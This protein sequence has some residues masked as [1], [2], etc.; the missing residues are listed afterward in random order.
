MFLGEL[1]SLDVK[2]ASGVGLSSYTGFPSAY[3]PDWS[4]A[5]RK[6]VRL[7]R[8]EGRSM[9]EESGWSEP[10]VRGWAE[11]GKLVSEGHTLPGPLPTADSSL[12]SRGAESTR[13]PMLDN[14]HRKLT[15]ELKED[16]LKVPA[17]PTN[18]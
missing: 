18:K 16:S 14:F 3:P 11:P 1:E 9:E 6:I 17:A 15:L 5:K 8:G 12:L 4:E 7:G 2:H 10:H 13:D